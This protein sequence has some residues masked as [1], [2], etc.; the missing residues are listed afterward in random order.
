MAPVSSPSPPPPLTQ[1]CNHN[2][3]NSCLTSTLTAPPW[4][5]S[6]FPQEPDLPVYSIK[7]SCYLCV[8]NFCLNNCC[9]ALPTLDLFACFDWQPMTNCK[10][11]YWLSNVANSL[12]PYVQYHCL[13]LGPGTCCQLPEFWQQLT[14]LTQLTSDWEALY[15]LPKCIQREAALSI[16]APACVP[17]TLA[18]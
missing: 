2:D 9:P 14:Q 6:P 5:S 15:L 11:V 18:C 7:A 12:K 3:M 17:Q 10:L 4:V 8:W 16:S 1:L 13:H